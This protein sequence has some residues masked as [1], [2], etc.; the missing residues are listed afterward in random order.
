M[1]DFEQ[2]RKEEEA[3]RRE[4]AAQRDAARRD[5][6]AQGA[7]APSA[8]DGSTTDAANLVTVF[9]GGVAAASVPIAVLTWGTFLSAAT[10]GIGIAFALLGV[11]SSRFRSRAGER[12]VAGEARLAAFAG[13]VG[14]GVPWQE[15]LDRAKDAVRASDLEPKR[16]AETLGALDAAAAEIAKLNRKRLTAGGK[17]LATRTA[18][19]TQ[20]FIANCD[21]IAQALSLVA[22]PA[23][24]T[25][26]DALDAITYHLSAEAEARAEL[27]EAL[28]LAVRAR[29]G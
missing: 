26:G 3:A 29:Q 25:A 2:R 18:E 16:A 21:E 28:K 8:A 20:A 17:D 19:R 4:T 13:S 11:A 22:A 15:A 27:D 9:A 23:G 7:R 6:L 5:A 24:P 1:S 12:A 14:R 10:I